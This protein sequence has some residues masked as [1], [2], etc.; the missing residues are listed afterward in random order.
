MP[1]HAARPGRVHRAQR[2]GGHLRR[3]GR[4]R[5]AL[6]GGARQQGAS[7]REA[8]E[9]A[10][11]AG[12]LHDPRYLKGRGS[13]HRGVRILP[14]R[15]HHRARQHRLPERVRP[16][17]CRVHPEFDALQLPREDD[18]GVP[19]SCGG[20]RRG[21]ELRL[22]RRGHRCVQQRSEGV[23][24]AH[25]PG[26]GLHGRDGA[27]RGGGG[28]AHRG[29]EGRVA[30]GGLRPAE[31]Q[32]LQLQRRLLRKARGGQRSQVGDQPCGRGRHAGGRLQSGTLQSA[33]CR[34]RG[35]CKGGRDRR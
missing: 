11:S 1:R 3:V 29:D 25:L 33:G 2:R 10:Q 20:L 19:R 16:G 4:A 9:R 23:P 5:A 14:E 31:V 24:H 13:S 17:A 32:L 18:R 22:H 6:D 7:G 12:R 26:V 21:V 28:Q 15:V 27:V 35:S 34:H 8:R 30:W